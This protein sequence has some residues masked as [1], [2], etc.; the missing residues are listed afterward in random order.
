M[1]DAEKKLVCNWVMYRTQE[2]KP[3]YSHRVTRQSVWEE[4]EEYKLYMEAKKA[5]SASSSSSVQKQRTQPTNKPKKKQEEEQQPAKKTKKQTTPPLY[6]TLS[7]EEAREAFWKLLESKKVR[8]DTR[9]KDIVS[10]LEKDAR[11]LAYRK[12]GQ[13]KQAFAEYCGKRLK[14]ERE[15]R[16]V[17]QRQARKDFLKLLKETKKITSRTFISLSFL[18]HQTHSP[19]Y[20]T[21]QAQN[22]T[23]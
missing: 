14:I 18:T 21:T 13:R 23:I 22:G 19:T 9:W 17:H 5:I 4:P 7:P 3:Y 11:F 6:T 8:S 16:R 10:K 20:A 2:G 1:S 15:E 12:K